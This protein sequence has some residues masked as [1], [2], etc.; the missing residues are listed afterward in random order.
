MKKTYINPSLTIVKVQTQQMLAS[1]PG[2]GGNYNG[3]TP[4]SRAGRFDDEEEE[5]Y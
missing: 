1:S 4:E 3:G 2:L 5:E